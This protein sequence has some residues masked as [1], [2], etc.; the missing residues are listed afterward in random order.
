MIEALR[1]KK[2]DQLAKVGQAHSEAQAA[3]KKRIQDELE[4]KEKQLKDHLQRKA[5]G[6]EAMQRERQLQAEKADLEE[7]IRGIERKKQV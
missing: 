7:Q 3:E 5:R 6:V 1:K 4:R 2:E